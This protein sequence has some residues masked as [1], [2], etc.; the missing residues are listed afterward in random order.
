MIAAY[1]ARRLRSVAPFVLSAIIGLCAHVAVAHAQDAAEQQ[2]LFEQMLRQ[3][4]NH[5][6]TFEYVRV[7]TA[8]GDYEAAIGALERLMFFNPKLTRVKYELG[9]LYFRLGSYEMAKRYFREAQASPDLDPVTRVRIETYLPDTEKQTQASRLSGFVQTGIRSQT[10]A[11]F[12]PS[13]GTIRLGG[14]DLALL[15]TAQKQ[16]DVNWFG[17]AG[18]SHDYDLGNQRGDMLETRFIGYLTQ[19]QR[20]DQYNVGLFDISFGPRLALSPEYLPG[21][22]I[23]PYVVGGNTWLDGA[24]YMSSVGAGVGI[25]VPVNDRFTF[26]PDFEWRHADFNNNEVVPVSGFNTGDWYTTGMAASY[27]IAQNI[28]LDARGLYRRGESAFVF[29]SFDQWAAEAA[30][31]FEFAPPWTM[32]PRNWSIAPFVKYIDTSFDA[33]NPF[34]DPLTARHDQQWSVGA[35]FNAPFTRTFGVTAAIQYDHVASSLPNYRLN[36]FSVMVGPTAR[37]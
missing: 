35:M 34:I 32:I 5:D 28:N 6:L 12:A 36:N 21:V 23:K 37:F 11:S 2:R 14:Q 15:P 13:T 7:A 26:G 1:R 25:K 27:R 22:T 20:F 30:I 17:L 8:R 33:P 16:S 9:A 31:T 18:V 24:S 10:N 4:G 19:Q 3:P 29:Q